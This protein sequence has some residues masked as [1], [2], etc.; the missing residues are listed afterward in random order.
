MVGFGGQED[1]A[2]S[3]YGGTGSGGEYQ[4]IAANH[5]RVARA[6]L[7]AIQSGDGARVRKLQN[8]GTKS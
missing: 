4:L 1:V 5:W 3:N 8:S 6:S 7:I 2:D